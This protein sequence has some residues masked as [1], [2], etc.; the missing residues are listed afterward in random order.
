MALFT[1]QEASE[2]KPRYR[3]WPW[4]YWAVPFARCQ[5]GKR[6]VLLEP[7][8]DTTRHDT[9]RQTR[10]LRARRNR[11]GREWFE[12]NVVSWH[13]LCRYELHERRALE[14]TAGIVNNLI[15]PA[16]CA[17][18]ITAQVG[19]ARSSR[20]EVSA[21]SGPRSWEQFVQDRVALSGGFRR[22]P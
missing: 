10:Q 7:D 18:S 22:L 2:L 14:W 1:E 5:S 21:K 11:L 8:K 13:V 9:T 17:S 12:E 19:P 4:V 3:H 15:G 20:P 16:L 6:L